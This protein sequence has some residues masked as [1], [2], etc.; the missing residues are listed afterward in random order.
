MANTCYKYCL[1][2][3]DCSDPAGET[4]YIPLTVYESAQDDG[5]PAE[6]DTLFPNIYNTFNPPVPED[7]VWY[8]VNITDPNFPYTNFMARGIYGGPCDDPTL[9]LCNIELG[10]TVLDPNSVEVLSPLP[11]SSECPSLDCRVLTNCSKPIETIVAGGDIAFYTGM[12]VSLQEYPGKFWEVGEATLCLG[13]QEIVTVT[14]TFAT[15]AD[16]VVPVEAPYT[17]VEPKPDRNFSAIIVS[18]QEIRDNIKFGNAYYDLFRSLKYGINNF[19][20]NLTLER[21]WMRKELL[22]LDHLLDPTV[23]TITTPVVPEVCPEPGT[24]N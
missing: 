22:D 2:G 15:C 21:T 23:C 1:L 7:A 20:D 9:N 18:E 5:Y 19:C 24:T 11:Q 10:G 16:T 6:Y 3:A 17:R 12:V 14:A 4:L 8:L 13:T